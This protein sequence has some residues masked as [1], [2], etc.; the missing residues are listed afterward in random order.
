[1]RPSE[2]Q[3]PQRWVWAGL[4]SGTSLAL[5][6]SS[7]WHEQQMSP[8]RTMPVAQVPCCPVGSGHSP[9]GPGERRGVRTVLTVPRT[10]E[11]WRRLLF[12]DVPA[13]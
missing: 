11:G 1:M 6:C 3:P 4:G 8:D 10:H 9:L 2:P 5:C 13:E 7:W 12:L